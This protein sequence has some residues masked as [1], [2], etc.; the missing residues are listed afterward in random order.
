MES[1][2]R[3]K[4]LM[5][6]SNKQQDMNVDEIYSQFN[7]EMSSG[8][9][10][11]TQSQSNASGPAQAPVFPI[12]PVVHEEE[13]ETQASSDNH[14]GLKRKAATTSDVEMVGTKESSQME[15]NRLT[16]SKRKM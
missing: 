5:D 14:R 15:K 9:R 8:G 6:E 10:S 12:L 11:Q 1:V 4:A 2:K 7:F 3:H 13:E 16:S